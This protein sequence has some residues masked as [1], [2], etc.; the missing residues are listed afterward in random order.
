MNIM[1][2]E[3]EDTKRT[4]MEPLKMKNTR[5]KVKTSMHRITKLDTAEQFY[6]NLTRLSI[7]LLHAM[8]SPF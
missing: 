2:S 6:Y 1:T 8:L 7:Q 5:S 3:M 4:G